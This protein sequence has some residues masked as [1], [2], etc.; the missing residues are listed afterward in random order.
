[1]ALQ[2]IVMRVSAECVDISPLW[3]S[4][5]LQNS[6]LS[7][8]WALAGPDEGINAGGLQ[9]KHMLE[10][11]IIIQLWTDKW[12]KA[13]EIGDRHDPKG[14]CLEGIDTQGFGEIGNELHSLFRGRLN[15]QTA[16]KA[17]AYIQQGLKM[18]VDQG[19]VAR[20][21]VDSQTDIPTGSLIVNI[22]G[23]SE[24]GDRVYEQRWSFVWDQIAM[25]GA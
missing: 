25:N 1:M 21:D 10:T 3:D 22:Q 18:I 16:M 24:S 20:F 11:A 4:V 19:A 7:I 13:N 6:P 17:K 12:S 9:S 2:E 23:Y 14:W 8:D 15:A 5:I